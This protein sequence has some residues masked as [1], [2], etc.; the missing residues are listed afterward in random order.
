MYLKLF[1]SVSVLQANV[2]ELTF[3]LAAFM[4]HLYLFT[5]SAETE[6]APFFK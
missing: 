1:I 3:T 6:S 2:S 5:N 4:V